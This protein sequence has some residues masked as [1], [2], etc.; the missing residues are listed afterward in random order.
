MPTDPHVDLRVLRALG[1]PDRQRVVTMLSER[2]ATAAE[3]SSAL[4]MPEAEVRSHLDVLLDNDAVEAADGT[5][6]RAA[7]RPFLDDAH[8]AQLPVEVRR[9]LFA[10]TIRWI[11]EDVAP[12][13]ANDGFDDLRAHVSRTRLDLD[14]RGWG[15]V[16]D[17]LAGVLDRMM[18]V[19]A[20]SIARVTRGE[21]AGT[22]PA[23]VAILSFQR[24]NG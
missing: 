4:G 6:Y 16:A 10:Q 22:V 7:I 1:D 24:P 8:W 2:V 21:S 9:A 12:A 3:I 13:L 18:E 17:L 19:H 14:A 5:S 11:V 23:E 20:E 15:E